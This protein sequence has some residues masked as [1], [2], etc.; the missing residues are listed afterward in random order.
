MTQETPI[1]LRPDGS[2]D[3]AHYI[4]LGRV[5]R[6]ETAHDLAKALR[7]EAPSFLARLFRGRLSAA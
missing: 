7:P 4:A 3:T 1:R 6:S 2:I 5:S